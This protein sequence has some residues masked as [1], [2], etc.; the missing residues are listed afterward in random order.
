[1]LH[2]LINLNPIFTFCIGQLCI[3]SSS[4]TISWGTWRI[5]H[6][7]ASSKSWFTMDQHMRHNEFDIEPWLEFFFCKQTL[8]ILVLHAHKLE[9]GFFEF[10]TKTSSLFF[11]CN[12]IIS[13]FS[14]MWS[15][16]QY[17]KYIFIFMVYLFMRTLE[18]NTR[19]S[20]TTYEIF[21]NIELNENISP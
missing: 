6:Y 7:I 1:M 4:N 13:I 3:F 2:V 18:S 20:R 9:H 19:S 10:L 21:I 17:L 15:W 16:F 11:L 8:K 5:L 12:H 14:N